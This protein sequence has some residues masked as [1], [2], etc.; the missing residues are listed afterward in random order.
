MPIIDTS[1][2]SCTIGTNTLKLDKQ[3]Q[4]FSLKIYDKIKSCI[5][6]CLETQNYDSLFRL[7]PYYEEPQKFPLLVHSGETYRIYTILQILQLEYKYHKPLYISV[8]RNYTE[9]LSQYYNTVFSLRRIELNVSDALISQAKEYL[10]SIPLSCFAVECILNKERFENFDSIYSALLELYWDIWS[11]SDLLL[12]CDFWEK[13]NP[14]S[15]IK[16]LITQLKDMLYH[17]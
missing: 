14:T 17:E 4:Q 7:L 8:T 5:N 1:K 3:K 11:S 10:L 9:L 6:Q 16:K 2:S 12:L 15:D 13:K